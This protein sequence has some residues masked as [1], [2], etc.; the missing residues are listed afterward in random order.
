MT[1]TPSL[2][3]N[4]RRLARPRRIAVLGLAALVAGGWAASGGVAQEPPR[5]LTLDQAVQASG[6]A[7][8]DVDEHPGGLRVVPHRTLQGLGGRPN[9][10]HGST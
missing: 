1:R 9:R 2:R 6:I 3:G 7:I 5:T 10:R 8:D 4:R